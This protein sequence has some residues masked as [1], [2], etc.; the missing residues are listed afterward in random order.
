[1]NNNPTAILASFSTMKSMVDAKQYQ[2]PYQILAEF[3]QYI[4][5]KNNLHSFT[6]VEMKNRLLEVFGF[7][8]PEAVVRTATRGLKFINTENGIHHVNN[9]ELKENASFAT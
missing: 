8:V 1:M 2:S 7:N 6:A 3:I 4:I 9:S 5:T